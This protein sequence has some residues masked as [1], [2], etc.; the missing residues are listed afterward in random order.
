RYEVRYEEGQE[1]GGGYLKLLSEGAEKS[2]TAVQDKTPYTIMF[3]PDKCGATGKVHLIFRYTN[4]KNG[5]TDEYHA[6]QPLNLGTDYWD[7]HK[8][9][10]YT[11]VV[12]PDGAFTVSVDQKQIMSGSMLND[13]IPS[14]QPP[15]EIADPND[16]KPDDWDDRAEIEDES[17]VKPDDWDESQPREVVD[18]KAEKPSDW[19]ENEP[20]LI[21]DPEATKPADWDAD[22]DGD[23]EPPMIDNPACKGVSGCGPWKKP[24]IPNPLY[25]GKWVR[26]RI[27]NPAYKGVWS[28]RKIENPNYFEPKPFD[29]LAPI[30][31]IG[32]ELWTMSQNIIF[33]NILV[34]ESEDLAA[35]V[36]KQTYVVRRAEDQRLAS[37]QGKGAGIIQGI[38]DAA[39]EKP[40]LWVVYV[41]CILIPVI[42]I[43][44][45]CFGRK[46]NADITAQRKKTDAPEADDEVPN[47]VDDEEDEKEA[48]EAEEPAE[49]P[50]VTPK[51]SP[52]PPQKTHQAMKDIE[53]DEGSA[54]E[55]EIVDAEPSEGSKKSPTVTKR[56]VRR[57]D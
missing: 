52:V 22:M 29:G 8:T 16:K 38:I 9:H 13:L 27:P 10:L 53:D 17:A 33:D 36:A 31:V 44:V 55:P 4:P 26:P 19:L 7:D 35:D 57:Q 18:E 28:P 20:E 1:C 37:S 11:L 51:G 47:L 32:I 56:R 2:L 15:K 39:N 50:K 14:L 6:K 23:W 3:G 21:P 25:K 40:W 42:L 48:E 41:L 5:S 12:K 30:T 45:C 43:G 54:S 46:S 34:C 49:A 24:L